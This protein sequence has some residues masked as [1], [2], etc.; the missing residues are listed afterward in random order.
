MALDWSNER[1]VRLY[2]RITGDMALW[3]WQAKAIWPWL[4]ANADR[5]GVI[6]ARR[7]ARGVAALV[8][9]PA[10]VVDVGLADLLEDGCIVAT[11]EGYAIPNYVEAQT[12]RASENKRAADYRA[13]Q[14]IGSTMADIG[15]DANSSV[16]PNHTASHGVTGNHTA[17]HGVTGNHDA[18][19]LVTPSRA[20]QSKAEH[21]KEIH[22]QSGKPDGS[23]PLTLLPDDPAPAKPDR[24]AEFARV[25]VG[26]INAL[27]GRAFD[28]ASVATLKLCR[29][30]LGQGRTPADAVTVARAK[31][32]EWLPKP[33]MAARVCPGTLLAAENFARYLDEIRAGPARST[34]PPRGQVPISSAL[35]VNGDQ[36]L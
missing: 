33:D 28:P 30:L 24:V 4:I 9:M 27:T 17:S 16:T 15:N 26:E 36:P 10:E 23:G 2:T 25:A 35:H 34:A 7:G 13:R 29:A 21:S 22:T 1:Y 11:P 31:A 19:R 20:E 12:A 14:R 5:A 6:G 18:S 8:G 32:A 3:C